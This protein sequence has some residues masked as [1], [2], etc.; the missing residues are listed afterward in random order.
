VLF[1]IFVAL[2]ALFLVG[3]IFYRMSLTTVVNEA[4]VKPVEKTQPPEKFI[5]EP[6]LPASPQVTIPSGATNPVEKLP[7]ANPLNKN[8]N[9]FKDAYHNPFE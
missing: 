3:A 9:P 2:V 5:N 4:P 8:P 1:V 6:S 7:D